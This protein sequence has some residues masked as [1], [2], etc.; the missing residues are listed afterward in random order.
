MIPILGARS[1]TQL[2]DDLAVLEWELTEEQLQRLEAVSKI[3][4]GFPHGFLDGNRY[5]FGATFDQVDNHR[6]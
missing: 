5:I 3:D 4:L 6:R 2:K 1:A